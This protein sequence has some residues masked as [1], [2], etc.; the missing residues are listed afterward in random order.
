MFVVSFVKKNIVFEEVLAKLH[1]YRI[2]YM[3][4]INYFICYNVR[5][6]FQR[7]F[8][9]A[10]FEL[11]RLDNRKM[12]R[13]NAVPDVY[14]SNTINIGEI[15]VTNVKEEVIAGEEVDVNVEDLV[16]CVLKQEQDEASEQELSPYNDQTYQNDECEA[17]KMK[18]LKIDLRA[19]KRKIQQL[20]EQ[21]ETL[22][23]NYR[24]VFNEDQCEI[25]T[26]GFGKGH[27][28]SD[29]TI[30]KALR[31]YVACGAKGYEEILQQK[32]PYPS[33]RTLQ[34]RIK[35]L[36]FCSDNVAN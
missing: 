34:H 18:Q 12:L 33:I 14:D 30:N 11:H 19:A 5:I 9:D 4:Q 10:Q 31:L 32:L 6:A 36:K 13:W 16:E 23:K 27:I 3:D 2:F 20:E 29:E 15:E 25:L 17:Y 26:S 24:D 28:W 7:H 35:S 21:V 1:N 8:S 22:N